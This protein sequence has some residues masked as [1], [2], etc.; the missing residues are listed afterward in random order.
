MGFTNGVLKICDGVSLQ[1]LHAHAYRFS[2][3]AITHIA[4]SHNS[5]YLAVAVST[6]VAVCFNFSA[7]VVV[8]R[9]KSCIWLAK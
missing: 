3:D 2:R 6:S 5:K 1:D 4:F 8:K 9:P 7:V